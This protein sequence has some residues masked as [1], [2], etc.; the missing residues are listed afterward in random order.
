[1]TSITVFTAAGAA[2]P[3][4]R[5]QALLQLREQQLI[6]QQAATAAAVAVGAP[7]GPYG[8]PGMRASNGFPGQVGGFGQAPVRLCLHP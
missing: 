6:G 2:R 7:Q 3:P 5:L 1:M 8:T 4:P